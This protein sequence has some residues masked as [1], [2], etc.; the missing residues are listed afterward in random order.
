MLEPAAAHCN[1]F[2]FAHPAYM[3]DCIATLFSLSFTAFVTAFFVRISCRSFLRRCGAALTRLKLLEGLKL[4]RSQQ[5]NK[6]RE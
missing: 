6:I 4:V 1:L 3:D 5:T 2:T